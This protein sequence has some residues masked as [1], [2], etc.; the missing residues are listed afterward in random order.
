VKSEKTVYVPN[1]TLRHLGFLTQA[2][3]KSV[4]V[5]KE[6]VKWVEGAGKSR[7]KKGGEK[8]D[9]GDMRLHF[10]AYL[11]PQVKPHFQDIVHPEQTGR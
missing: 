2:R 7:R 6:C 10:L 5:A 11:G 9:R 3:I 1:R 4:Q 8:K